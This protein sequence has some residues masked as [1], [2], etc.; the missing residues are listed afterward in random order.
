MSAYGHGEY[1][2]RGRKSRR[3]PPLPSKGEKGTRLDSIDARSV[4]AS[5]DYTRTGTLCKYTKPSS[6]LSASADHSHGKLTA[7]DLA[8]LRHQTDSQFGSAGLR[9]SAPSHGLMYGHPSAPYDYTQQISVPASRA[10]PS[11]TF[12]H[13]FDE[14]AKNSIDG[15]YSYVA[16]RPETRSGQ[17]SMRLSSRHTPARYGSGPVTCYYGGKSNP[18]R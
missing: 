5:T 16:P 12:S 3:D 6:H 7:G 11:T 14:G 13:P 17:G 8:R 9:P 4:A 18:Y 10:T 15:Y 2:G 1:P